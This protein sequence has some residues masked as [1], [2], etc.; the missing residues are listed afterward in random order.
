MPAPARTASNEDVNCP[1]A[2]ADEEPEP[3]GV[4][5][6]V[7]Q[8][9]AG[10]LGSPGSVGMGGHAQHVQ[11]AVADLEH[12]QHVQPPQGERAVD[13]EEVHR[14]HAGGL[15]TQELPPTDVGV[16]HRRRWDPVALQDPPD[17]RG[18]DA[19]A[20]LEQL[21]LQPLVSPSQVLPRH[22]HHQ[23]GEHVVDRWP[24]DPVRVGPAST[25]EAA[26]PAQDRVRSDETMG[27]QCAGQPSDERGKDRS[28]RPVQ[29]WP[30]VGAAQD[31]DLVA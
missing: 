27:S 3:S 2:V 1:V 28:V 4:L 15:G 13:V 19:V 24:P 25:H 29:A 8:Q 7:H 30:R 17:R 22:P 14:E 26:M 20:E 12:E 16:P 23:G 18:A 5:A 6:E 11:G 21:A 9:V 10:L 31:G